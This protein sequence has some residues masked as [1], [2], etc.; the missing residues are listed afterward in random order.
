MPEPEPVDMAGKSLSLAGE[1][2]TCN[3]SARKC[4]D[5]NVSP[6][7]VIRVRVLED[8]AWWLCPVC[9]SRGVSGRARLRET[10]PGSSFDTRLEAIRLATDS[11]NG[12]EMRCEQRK[13]GS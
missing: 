12:G 11:W 2:F 3:V 9:G 7:C 13:V 6:W 1:A 5:C 4:P 8:E 10:S